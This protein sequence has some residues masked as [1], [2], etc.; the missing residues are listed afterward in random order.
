L[1]EILGGTSQNKQA[2]A[3]PNPDDNETP[4]QPRSQ[5]V[6][7]PSSGNKEVFTSPFPDNIK[8]PNPLKRQTVNFTKCKLSLDPIESD[9]DSPKVVERRPVTRS[10]G[11]KKAPASSKK[12]SRSA[13]KPLSTLRSTPKKKM[14]DN[15]FTFNEKCTPKTVDQG[16]M[17]KATES[18]GSGSPD[19]AKK[20]ENRKQPYLSP[21]SPTEDEG[22]KSSETSFAR[23]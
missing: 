8:T 3:S 14:L 18:P 4:D 12:Q 1:W 16:E 22:I 23:G 10:L 15:V 5:T 6:K 19:S 21:L 9:S 11:R 2:V 17:N 13:K 7:G 20:R